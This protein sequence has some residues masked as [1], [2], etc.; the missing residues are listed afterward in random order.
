[1][2]HVR[3]KS[4]DGLGLTPSI[5]QVIAWNNDELDLLAHMTMLVYTKPKLTQ[6]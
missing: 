5:T 4:S 2:E 1:M 6:H 3:H